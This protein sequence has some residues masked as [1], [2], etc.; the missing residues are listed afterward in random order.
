M[1]EIKST[2]DIIMEKTKNLTLTEGEKQKFLLKAGSE[3][4]KG[5][6]QKFLEAKID[7]DELKVAFPREGQKIPE[8]RS[9]L[10]NELQE[11]LSLDE[12]NTKIFQLFEKLLGIEIAPFVQVINTFQN[13]MTAEK[14]KR[15]ALLKNDLKKRGVSGLSVIPNLF[16]D[17]EWIG[18]EKTLSNDFKQQLK[19]L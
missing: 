14:G 16:H 1:A 9:L 17:A 11:R 3:K 13:K 15:I 5:W 4:V 10:K 18:T 8:L 19:N 2:L 7:L 12:D 6:V